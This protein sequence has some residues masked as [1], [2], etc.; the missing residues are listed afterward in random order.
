MKLQDLL[1]EISKK[2][3]KTK[4]KKCSICGKRKKS[5]Q[6]ESGRTYENELICADCYNQDD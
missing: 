2:K 4:Y 6:L 3:I 1:E 5:V